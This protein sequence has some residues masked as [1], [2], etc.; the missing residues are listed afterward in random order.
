MDVMEIMSG[1]RERYA[2]IALFEPLQEL[3]RK[4]QVDERGK[5]ID[6][7]G[8]GL[9]SLL[10]FFEQKLMRNTK[11]GVKELAQFLQQATNKQY[12]LQIKPFE[13]VS[14][15][16]IHTFRP[17]SGKKVQVQFL[18]WEAS[19]EETI[20]FS[21]LKANT[22]DVKTNSQYYSLDE[23][24][25]ELVFATKE[26]YSEFQLSINQLV[27]RKQLEKGEFKGALRQ[28]NEMRIDV[29]SLEERIVKLSHEIKRNI[30]SEET[31]SRYEKL[32]EDI[33]FRLKLENEEFQELHEF[34]KETKERLYYKDHTKKE[35]ETY[36]L[37]LEISKQLDEVHAHHTSLLQKS[38][39]LKNTALQAAEESL[40]Y[41]GIDSFN[42][43]QDITSRIISAPLPLESMK[44]L[45][46]PFLSI[47]QTKQWSL[48]TIF[49]E[50]NLREQRETSSDEGFM[51]VNENENKQYQEKV[52][53]IYTYIMELLVTELEEKQMITLQQLIDSIQI[54]EQTTI[55]QTRYFYDFF[56][57]LHQRSPIQQDANVE[58]EESTHL[59]D[60]VK[61]LLGKKV[62]TVL[63]MSG[64]L[65]PDTRYSIQNMQIFIGGQTD[66]L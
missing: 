53:A 13:E 2:R 33:L 7:K 38:I 62:L 25:L 16:I 27:L 52:S 43:D 64:V 58:E 26:F 17:A 30:I 8:L 21:Y 47:Q 12:E 49:A 59:L 35:R 51:E 22:F 19:L 41:V 1:Y 29:E 18:N 56:L 9:L 44:G 45:L 23:D 54:S 55:L 14:R 37:V 32:L 4:K 48:G 5:Q 36:I 42:F 6:M 40:Y 66:A 46:D 50:Q 31:F 20:Q 24:G 61:N 63:E 39:D 11:A 60:G 3:D 28:I 57:L 10:F 34:V 15:T 65:H